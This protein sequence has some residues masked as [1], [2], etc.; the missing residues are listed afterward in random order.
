MPRR[1]AARRTEPWPTF[2]AIEKY[3]HVKVALAEGYIPDPA[4]IC[5]TADM[6]GKP[7]DT[8]IDDPAT[9]IDEAHNMPRGR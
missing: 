9:P 6:M 7:Y 3:R 2:A 8:M 4:N 1:H 5:E